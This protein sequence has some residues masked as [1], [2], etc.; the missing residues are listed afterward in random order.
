MNINDKRNGLVLIAVLWIVVVLTVIVTVLGRKGRLD[1]K[2]CLAGTEG[3]RCKWAS[4][5]GIEKAIA[6]LYEDPRESD[7]LMDLWSDN[8]EDFSNITLEKCWFSVEVIDEAGKLNINSATKEQLMGLPDMVEEIADAIIDWR[9]GDDTPRE[10]GA[11]GGYYE[12]LTYGYKARNGPFRTIREL[13]LVKGVTEELFYGEDTNLNGRLDYNE[14]DEDENPPADNGDDVLDKGWISY[15]TC[16]SYDNSQ[17][18]QGN[19]NQNSQNQG[20]QNQG[21]QNQS[22]QDQDSQNQGNQNQSNQSQQDQNQ[23]SQNQNNQNNSTQVTSKVNINTASE[24][25]LA[26]LLGGGDSAEQA[27]QSI[28]AYRETLLY[29][30]E[31]ISELVE[32]GVVRQNVLEQIQNYV[33]T[34]SNVYTIRCVARADRNG[35]YGA[36]LQTEAVVDR[37]SSPCRILYWYQG[38]SN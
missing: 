16:Y 32:Q 25:V 5:A 22:N 18:G 37:S 27:A 30:I 14:R 36:T 7:C 38:A 29:G 20:S 31:D 34:R 10:N 6:V 26:A 24:V 8:D 3:L 1:T 12:N 21:T 35:P 13:L 11:E 19:R 23:D 4:R 33:T 15:L 9:D 2:V 17:S 28:I